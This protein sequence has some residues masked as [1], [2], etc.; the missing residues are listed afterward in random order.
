MHE[1]LT[2]PLKEVFLRTRQLAQEQQNAKAVNKLE[3]LV[4]QLTWLDNQVNIPLLAL[5]FNDPDLYSDYIVESLPNEGAEIPNLYE[6]TMLLVGV[7]LISSLSVP[8]VLE[9][10]LAKLENLSDEYHHEFSNRVATLLVGDRGGAVEITLDGVQ[11]HFNLSAA[12]FKEPFPLY[13]LLS[14][15]AQRS[16]EWLLL[17]EV[18]PENVFADFKYDENSPLSRK[19]QQRK[20]MRTRHQLI[21]LNINT[22]N[23]SFKDQNVP[24]KVEMYRRNDGHV[25]AYRLVQ[26]SP[27]QINLGNEE[28]TQEQPAARAE[29]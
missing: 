28:E 27:Q 14:K 8:A 23:T 6:N 29:K 19:K 7:I 16:G 9:K 22:L 3:V 21:Q 2:V 25:L 13:E 5:A 18:L 11:H 4:D 20:Y 26:H 1:G 24:L 12:P 15:L 10:L 17:S